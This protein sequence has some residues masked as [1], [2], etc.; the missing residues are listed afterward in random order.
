MGIQFNE[1][2]YNWQVPGTFM[3]VRPNNSNIGLLGYPSRML[4]MGQTLLAAGA[5]L[6]MITTPEQATALYGSGSMLEL[7]VALHLAAN[8]YLPLDVFAVVDA[9]GATVATGSFTVTGAW[10]T[11]GTV[12]LDIAGMPVLVPVSATDTPIT[13]TTNAVAAINAQLTQIVTQAGTA[14]VGLPVIASVGTATNIIKLTSRHAGLEMN[15]ID[16]WV[17]MSAGST[18]PAGMS[19]AI[20]AMSGGA[21]NPSIAGAFA[22]TSGIWYTDMVSPWNDS[23]NLGLETSSLSGDFQA[24]SKHDAVMYKAMSGTYGTISAWKASLNSQFRTDLCGTNLPTP[25]WGVAASLAGVC[26][27]ARNA[28]PA[29]QLKGKVLP[30][31]VGPRPQDRFLQSQQQLLL[32]QGLSTFSVNSSGAVV[33]QRVVSEELTNVQGVA[34]PTWHDI[35]SI[36]VASYIRYDWRTYMDLTYPNGKLAPDGSLAAEYDPSVATPKK[37]AGS[38]TARMVSYEKAGLIQ[39]GAAQAAQATFVIN[40]GNKNRLDAYQ[41]VQSIGNLMIFAGVLGFEN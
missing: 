13:F 27:A 28:D 3:E 17:S 23:T 16:L 14:E 31:V 9:T 6:N 18:L 8:P 34:D 32:A 36:W 21:T 5:G 7:M 22:A 10:T 19:I 25:A 15:N 24:M 37:V 39:N 41:P 20:A 11:N 35:M 29:R 40:A 4:L 2:P 33:L 30:F 38:W 26:A 12:E 1:I